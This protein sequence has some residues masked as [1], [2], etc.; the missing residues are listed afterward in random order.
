MSAGILLTK[1]FKVHN[2]DQYQP[3][4][5][6][7]L[8][9]SPQATDSPQTYAVYAFKL[10]KMEIHPTAHLETWHIFNVRYAVELSY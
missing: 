2:R 9:A 5:M 10:L 6:V 8:S 1:Q 7:T 3:V 4:S